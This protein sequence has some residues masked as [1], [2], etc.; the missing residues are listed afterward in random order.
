MTCVELLNYKH[1]L[2][3]KTISKQSDSE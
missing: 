2:V 3:L 1:W